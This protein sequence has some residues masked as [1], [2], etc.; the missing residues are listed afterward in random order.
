MRV[1][2]GV[3]TPS[4]SPSRARKVTLKSLARRTCRAVSK[5]NCF[6]R[7]AELAYYFL[8]AFFPFLIFLLSFMTFMPGAQE[9]ILAWFSKVMPP[10]ATKLVNEW[11]GSVFSS[12]S[13][14]LLPFGLVLSLWWASSGVNALVAALNTAYEINEGRPLWKT[15][16][17]A[18]G[19]T[20]TLSLLVIGGVAIIT[21]GE[22]PA[23][24]I[25]DRLGLEARFSHIWNLVRYVTGFAMLIVG[26]GI[27]YHFGPNVEQKWRWVAPG[28]F[29][30]GAGFIGVSFV[31]SLY[32]KLVPSYDATYGS[33]GA[34]I[35]FMLWLYLI[36]LI[37]FIGGEINSEI[38]DAMGEPVI[39]K[40]EPERRKIA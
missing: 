2:A 24:W 27:I 18:F 39:E 20:I 1:L 32:L 21:F 8:L 37:L 34:M 23:S 30:A 29:F 14:G 35:V 4:R 26:I 38:V 11:L 5:H 15:Y 33:L 19:L 3:F 22:E 28:T 25:A 17:L 10:D 31:L 13:R 9:V 12:R 7:A 36:G 40:E 6:G 16:F